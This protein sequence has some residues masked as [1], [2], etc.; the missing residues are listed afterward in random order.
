ML[1][2]EQSSFIEE[3]VPGIVTDEGLR[4]SV[5][6]LPHAAPVW[7]LVGQ[8]LRIRKQVFIAKKSWSLWAAENM[9]F[10][11]YDTLD[12]VYVIAHK[13]GEVVGGGR[14]RRTDQTTGT[15]AVRYTYMIRDAA[16][17]ILPGLPTELCYSEP[18]IDRRIWEL[19]RFVSTVGHGVAPLMLRTIN[20]FLY[21]QGATGCLCL[22]TPAF[23]RMASRAGWS[24]YQEGPLCGNEDGRFLVFNCA[25]LDPREL[26]PRGLGRLTQ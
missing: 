3:S 2:I 23:L 8:Y 15:G 7:N 26:G 17:G 25:I 5:L 18:P 14:L 1:S 24:V 22:G 20:D 9:E 12:T 4:V 10:E 16:L 13:D 6:R 11:Q 21:S 19:T